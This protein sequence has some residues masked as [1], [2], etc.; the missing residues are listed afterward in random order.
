M[1]QHRGSCAAGRHEMLRHRSAD[2]VLLSPQGAANCGHIGMRAVF[3][4]T[5]VLTAIRAIFNL[6]VKR[7]GMAHADSE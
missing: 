2:H 4:G 7:R 1:N 6:V 5:R 3:L